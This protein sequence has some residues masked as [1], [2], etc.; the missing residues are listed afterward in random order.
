LEVVLNGRD[1]LFAFR[2]CALQGRLLRQ[3]DRAWLQGRLDQL[4]EEKHG[5]QKKLG[6]WRE[7]SGFE[8]MIALVP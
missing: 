5:H 7:D 4:G 2:C 8:I 1:G 6:L 3:P